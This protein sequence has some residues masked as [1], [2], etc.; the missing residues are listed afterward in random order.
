ML[1]PIC[2]RKNSDMKRDMDLIRDILLAIESDS[3]LDGTRWIMPS[4]DGENL[5]II[6][7]SHSEEEVAYHLQLL[8][9]AGLVRGNPTMD[10]P[11]ISKLTWQGHEFLDNIKDQDVWSKT[12]DKIKGLSGVALSVVGELAAAEVKKRFGLA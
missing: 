9:E 7:T 11:M 1:V 6:G 10:M 8:V 3:R 12:K 4:S 2:E 5:G